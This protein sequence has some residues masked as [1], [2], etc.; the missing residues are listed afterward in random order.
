MLSYLGLT[1]WLVDIIGIGVIVVS[2]RVAFVRNAML[3]LNERRI[4]SGA[5]QG[6]IQKAR[7]PFRR[8]WVGKNNSR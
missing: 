2:H 7:D 6:S 8:L 3:E 1:G 5:K 4:Y